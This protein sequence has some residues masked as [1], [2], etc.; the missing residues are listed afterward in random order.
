MNKVV[1]R[2]AQIA[3][4]E[5]ILEL[6]HELAVFEGYHHKFR[7]GLADI[8]QHLFEQKDIGVLVATVGQRIEGILV[9]FFQS[10]TYDL[11]PWL[12]IKE[13]YVSQMHRGLGLGGQLLNHVKQVGIESK[14]SK[15]KWEVLTDNLKA[16][17]FYNHHG[18]ELEDD[19][20]IMAIQI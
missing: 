19:W 15:I 7:V 3:D 17:D 4:C 9:F 5:R 11:C 12:V 6:M 8:R 18:A 16:Q 14:C 1:I 10:F 13:L 20:R 2:N